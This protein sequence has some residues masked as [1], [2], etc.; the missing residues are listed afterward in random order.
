[1][2]PVSVRAMNLPFQP[3][4]VGAVP[5]APLPSPGGEHAGRDPVRWCRAGLELWS[6]PSMYVGKGHGPVETISRVCEV[7]ALAF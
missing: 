6:F 4:L 3:V 1:M 7:L 5:T 2:E